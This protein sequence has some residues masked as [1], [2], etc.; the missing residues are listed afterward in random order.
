MVSAKSVLVAA[1]LATAVYAQTNETTVVQPP[2][3]IDPGT[4]D[5]QITGECF[6][7]VR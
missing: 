7:F 4:L 6:C 1:V 3:T 5:P 2:L